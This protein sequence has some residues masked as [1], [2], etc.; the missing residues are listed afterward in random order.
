M[1]IFENTIII[2]SWGWGMNNWA[3]FYYSVNVIRNLLFTPI[4]ECKKRLLFIDTE[5]YENV[6][7]LIIHMGTEKQKYNYIL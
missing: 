6:I 1:I 7:S 4:M 3:L 5:G 2:F